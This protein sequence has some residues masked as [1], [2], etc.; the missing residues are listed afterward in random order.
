MDGETERMPEYPVD[1]L[2]TGFH[3]ETTIDGERT[4]RQLQLISKHEGTTAEHTHVA[5]KG[6]S[7]SGN[8]TSDIPSFNSSRALS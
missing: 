8:T 2:H 1:V 5:R 7:A 4:Y 6:A 3:I